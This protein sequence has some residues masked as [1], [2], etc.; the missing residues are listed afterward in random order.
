MRLSTLLLRVSTVLLLVGLCMG[1]GMA[2]M[3][4]FRMRPTHAHLNLVGFVIMFLAGLYYR[5][6]PV[7][8]TMALAKAHAYLH[9]AASIVFPIG[10]YAVTVINPS[11][12][13]IAIIGSLL[14]LL[15]M[16]LFTIVVYRTSDTHTAS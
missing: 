11:Y 4:D 12:E 10:I 13:F 5:L 16:I 3:Q 7:A 14:F 15:S 9:I 6:V 2:M 8:E 1:I